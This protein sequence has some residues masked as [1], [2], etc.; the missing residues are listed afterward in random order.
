M[1]SKQIYHLHYN[2]KELKLPLD[3][4][5]KIPFDSEVRTFD[6]VFDKS[7]VKKHLIANELGR[8]GYNLV[9]MLK[10]VLFCNMINI[11]SLR[12][13][14]KAAKNDIR[15][16]W[17]TDEITPSH[18]AIGNFINKHLTT[19]LKDIFKEL[20]DYIIKND[21]V[22][23]DIIYIDGTK[24]ESAANKYTF[25]WRGAVEKFE[26][27][28]H[29]KI[30]KLI[31]KLNKEYNPSGI[32][33]N[34]YD[35]Y[36]LNYLE[37]I[38]MFLEKQ[39]GLSNPVFVYGSGKRKTSLQRFYEEISE[40]ITKLK[41]YKN[42]LEIMGKTRNS[43]SKTD[44]DAT[45]MR[46]KEDYMQ[47]QQLKPGYN[48]QIGV[49]DEYIMHLMISSE[50]SDFNTFI[51][52]L[53]GYKDIYDKY[54]KYPVADSGYG[55][56]ENY[57]Y[58]KLNGMELYQKYTMYEKD[59]SD[60]KYLNDEYRPHNLINIGEK[61]YQTKSGEVLFYTHTDKFNKDYYYSAKLGKNKMIHEE[62]L[63]Y[64]KEAIKNLK[65]EFGIELRVQRSIQVE[66]AFGVIKENYGI[67]RFRRKGNLKVWL[68][69][70]LTAIGYNLLKFHNKRYKIIE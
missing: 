32:S 14:E 62:N 65:S 61:K 39:I 58:L 47:N 52:F 50:R 24:I 30:T 3:L 6:E 22:N 34:E 18:Q 56:L 19:S 67:R 28:L 25:V 13:M 64:Q 33:F 57:R 44:H 7:G 29:L 9:S 11:Y 45:F 27:K 68:E 15:I 4:G 51:P 2:A 46:M 49:S 17:L 66:G 42:H 43:Y 63:N 59:T 10:L 55:S 31:K 1:N 16:M 60:K 54:P 23:T 41:E 69:M 37:N 53:E 12:D 20:N 21:N 5:I 8:D 40:Y 36:E 48:L 70:T 38:K 26:S 35:L